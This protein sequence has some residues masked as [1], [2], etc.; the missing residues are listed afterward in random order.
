MNDITIKKQ[1]I[2]LWIDTDFM[3]FGLAKSLQEQ[4]DCEL[5]AIIDITNKGK[6]FFEKQKFV[7]FKKVWYYHDHIK[8]LTKE[9]DYEYLSKFENDNNIDLWITAQN[10][11]IF[12]NFNNYHKF[13][14]E[15]ILLILEQECKLFE[16]I[17]KEVKPDFLFT[18]ITD[19][20]HNHIFSQT[21]NSHGVKCLMLW[22][23]KLGFKSLIVDQIN[24]EITHTQKLSNELSLQE[25]QDYQ[26]ENNS[27]KK[28]KKYQTENR[29]S[30][31]E[32]IRAALN[33]LFS[34]YDT[35]KTHYPYYG[36]TKLKVLFKE[37]I[38]RVKK[39]YR[40]SYI[41][42]FLIKNISNNDRPF[43][44]FPLH[45]NMDRV[46]L[47]GAPF[48]TN[49]I[50]VIKNIVKSLPINYELYVK[51]HP[52]LK[53][54]GWRKLSF[55]KELKS[56]PR[57]KLI[58]PSVDPEEIIRKSS[59]VISISG[60]AGLEAAFQ[61]KP[62]IVLVEQDYSFLDSVKKVNTFSDLS[63]AIKKMIG[64]S[65]DIHG[66]NQYVDYIKKNSFDFDWVDYNLAVQ[67][68]LF[69]GG[70]LADIEIPLDLMKSF[71]E[72]QKSTF[73]LLAKEHI[74]KINE[75]DTQK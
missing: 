75:Y 65:T 1:K 64:K 55:Y 33:F 58:H 24:K 4:Y 29:N 66:L 71:L 23:T 18:R 47:I 25:L 13:E 22:S 67:N 50:E 56:I 52:I 11:R 19:L 63:S 30:S 21:C 46:L 28:V 54:Y 34:S 61:N 36:R 20:Q 3:I 16:N 10:E 72:E 73:N 70:N 40:E 26:K 37:I 59:L 38:A 45:L 27:F 74:K 39:Q 32:L 60:T 9:P 62:S 41:N 17:L 14:T 7:N 12:Y 2:I 43:V 8:K 44:Y 35:N 69:Y 15:E 68:K 49:Q 42:K 48:Y 6:K 51:E 53:V 5:Y 31:K 57:V